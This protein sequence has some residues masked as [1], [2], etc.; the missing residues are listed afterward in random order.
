M[1]TGTGLDGILDLDQIHFQDMNPIDIEFIQMD[2][3]AAENFGLR[4]K[5]QFDILNDSGKR[6]EGFRLE[7]LHGNTTDFD[8]QDF[9]HPG[10]AH[11]HALGADAPQSF[12]PFTRLSPGNPSATNRGDLYVLGNGF[13]DDGVS[14][15]WTGLGIHQWERPN[16]LRNFT[17]RLTPTVPEPGT[18]ALVAGGMVTLIV[19][20]RV[21]RPPART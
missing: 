18:L 6:W 4:I 8:S 2:F 5:A 19:L 16:E 14:K 17:L 3:V 20:R 12:T 15:N 21:R 10:W 13:F 7:L 9:V 11:F 1:S